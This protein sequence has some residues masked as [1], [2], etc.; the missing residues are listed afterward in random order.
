[1]RLVMVTVV[2]G[3]IVVACDFLSD[4]GGEIVV[5]V[6]RKQPRGRG[7]CHVLLWFHIVEAEDIVPFLRDVLRVEIG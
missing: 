4:S 2:D 1:M 5:V 3:D 7:A 6:V